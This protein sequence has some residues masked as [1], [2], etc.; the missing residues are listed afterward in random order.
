ML[1]PNASLD[2]QMRGIGVFC[3]K[4]K[5]KDPIFQKVLSLGSTVKKLFPYR[6]K[7]EWKKD[8]KNN[9]HYDA[10]TLAHDNPSKNLSDWYI[11][12]R[13]KGNLT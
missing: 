2:G 5:L 1:L 8:E 12:A 6:K 13:E 11:D 7:E 3:P 4:A 10:Y 9:G